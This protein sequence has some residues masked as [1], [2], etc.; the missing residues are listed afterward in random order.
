MAE[1]EQHPFRH[2]LAPGRIGSDCTGLG[3]VR[4]A[5]ESASRTAA[6]L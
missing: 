1:I 2:L 5:F 3:F 4:G 6:A